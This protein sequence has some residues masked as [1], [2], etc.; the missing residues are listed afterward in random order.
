MLNYR[1]VL[2]IRERGEK[3]ARRLHESG[4]HGRIAEKKQ[5]LKDT[6]NKKRLG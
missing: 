4:L 1:T 2:D 6:N 3:R 5:Q